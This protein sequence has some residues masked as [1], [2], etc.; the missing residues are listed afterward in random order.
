MTFELYNLKTV[1]TWCLWELFARFDISFISIG[2]HVSIRSIVCLYTVFKVL[3]S[4]T[5][6]FLINFSNHLEYMLS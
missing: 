4:N 5:P 6:E 3:S 1:V 2:S